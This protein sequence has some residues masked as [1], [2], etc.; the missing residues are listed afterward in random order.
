M[1]KEG[2]P[3]FALA[4]DEELGIWLLDG[5]LVA[6]VDWNEGQSGEGQSYTRVPDATGKF[7]TVGN[8]TPGRRQPTLEKLN[9][10]IPVGVAVFVASVGTPVSFNREARRI[11]DGLRKQAQLLDML[12]FRRAD[13]R[14][15]SP[16]ELPLAQG[17]ALICQE[18]A[19]I[20]GIGRPRVCWW[21]AASRLR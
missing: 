15:V 21:E 4:S 17:C 5:T 10:K 1:D 16:K 11:V 3:G 20:I 18:A 7:Q 8:P 13:G 9:E 19:P 12:S 2:W 6:S 14:Q